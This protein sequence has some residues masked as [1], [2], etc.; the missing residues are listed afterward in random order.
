MLISTYVES[1]EC[2]VLGFQLRLYLVGNTMLR[3]LAKSSGDGVFHTQCNPD[4]NLRKVHSSDSPRKI[5]ICYILHH[6]VF[7]R[8]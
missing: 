8:L 1:G 5:Y 6:I 3:Q 7:G 2:R 4:L